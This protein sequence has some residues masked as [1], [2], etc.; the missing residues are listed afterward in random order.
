MHDLSNNNSIILIPIQVIFDLLTSSTFFIS[1]IHHSSYS[2]LFLL[3]MSE[4]L[5]EALK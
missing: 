3:L 5:Y 1:H 2:L 4:Q